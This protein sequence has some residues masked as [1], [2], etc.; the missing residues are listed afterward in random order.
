MAMMVMSMLIISVGAMM[1]ILTMVLALI[2]T[3]P[4]IMIF[5]LTVSVIISAI[6]P[7]VI[8]SIKCP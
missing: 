3:V 7:S 1:S 8:A 6:E 4:L 5:P 2:L